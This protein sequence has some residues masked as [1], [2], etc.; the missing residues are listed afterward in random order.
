METEW[1][2]RV[3]SRRAHIVAGLIEGELQAL[4]KIIGV[5]VRTRPNSFPCRNLHGAVGARL[6]IQGTT[7]RFQTNRSGAVDGERFFDRPLDG[8]PAADGQS[9]RGTHKKQRGESFH[10]WLEYTR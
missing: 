6:D 8:S 5:S 9:D 10:A 1:P 7:A 4:Q 2:V 3:F